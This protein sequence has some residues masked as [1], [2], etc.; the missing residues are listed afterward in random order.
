MPTVIEVFGIQAQDALTFGEALTES[1]RRGM[2]EAV[3]MIFKEI[4]DSRF[5]IH[6]KSR[7]P[8]FSSI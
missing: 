5:E 4:R 6:N 8:A 7:C 2:K 3:T 1:V